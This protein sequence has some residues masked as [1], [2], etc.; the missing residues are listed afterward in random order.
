MWW[1]SCSVMYDSSRP[2]GLQLTRL[3]CPWDFQARTLEWVPI[4]FSKGSSWPQ[5]Q[6]CVSCTACGFLP[7]EPAWKLKSTII[8]LKKHE[9]IF[10][11]SFHLRKQK[12]TA[13]SC[14]V[15]EVPGFYAGLASRLVTLITW[16]RKQRL[17]CSSW[18]LKCVLCICCFPSTPHLRCWPTL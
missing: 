14:V 18:K 13:S 12:G 16:G 6:S 9:E 4:P 8:Q 15:D 17:V 1:F 11:R 2:Y 10:P 3:L 7:S 5:D